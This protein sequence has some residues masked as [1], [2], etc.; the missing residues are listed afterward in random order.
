MKSIPNRWLGWMR[1]FSLEQFPGAVL[2]TATKVSSVVRVAAII[3]VL[4]SG[5]TTD[6]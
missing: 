2:A 3:L 5:E 6:S 4:T 1:W